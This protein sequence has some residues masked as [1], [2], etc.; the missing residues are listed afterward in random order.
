MAV[1]HEGKW[2]PYA[3]VDWMKIG[4]GDPFFGPSYTDLTRVLAGIRWDVLVFN[5]LK[6]EYNRDDR[7]WGV[8]HKL[9]VQSAFTF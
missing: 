4:A 3:G 8:A 2:S 9:V 6:L 7:P 1:V 5:A